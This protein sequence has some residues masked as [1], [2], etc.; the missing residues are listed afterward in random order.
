MEFPGNEFIAKAQEIKRVWESLPED[1]EGN[2]RLCWHSNMPSV[3]VI[4]LSMDDLH[5]ARSFMKMYID[6]KWT[7]HLTD[8][9]P[10][11][12]G[13]CHAIYRSDDTSLWSITVI[14]TEEELKSVGVLS[15]KCE[16]KEVQSTSL[17]IVCPV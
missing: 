10:V 14:T 9:R 8:V 3:S 4:V 5:K 2:I 6:S 15:D 13:N 11:G 1:V 7:D 17:T 16:I 12:E